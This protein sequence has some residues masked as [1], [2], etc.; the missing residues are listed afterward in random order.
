[1]LPKISSRSNVDMIGVVKTPIITATSKNQK[2]RMTVKY[3]KNK[4]AE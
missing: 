2:K 1:M 4:G 3:W